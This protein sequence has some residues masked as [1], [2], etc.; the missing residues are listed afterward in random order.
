MFP[1]FCCGLARLKP[2]QTQVG[3]ST[4]CAW[5]REM[6]LHPAALASSHYFFRTLTRTSSTPPAKILPTSSARTP[7]NA[8]SR[9]TV[10]ILSTNSPAN[11]ST[12]STAALRSLSPPSAKPQ[13]QPPWAVT[14]AA[15]SLAN[16]SASLTTASCAFKALAGDAAASITAAVTVVSGRLAAHAAATLADTGHGLA[17]GASRL[18]AQSD[19]APPVPVLERPQSTQ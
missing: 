12:N 16:A 6:C 7:T 11:L 19:L 3:Q 14:L 10:T 13:P 9:T 18:G 17:L 2:G 15:L 5:D 8:M 1:I 4:F